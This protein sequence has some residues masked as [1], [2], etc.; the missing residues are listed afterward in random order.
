MTD[1]RKPLYGPNESSSARQREALRETDRERFE[2]LLAHT[3]PGCRLVDVGCG[4]GQFLGLVEDRCRE[5]WAVDESPHRI[6]DVRRECPRAR[7][8][9]CRANR[10]AL[11][12]ERFDAVVTSQMLHEV[13]LFGQPDELNETVSEFGRILVPGGR[14][15]LLDHQDAGEG[16]VVV[17]L[18]DAQMAKLTEFERKYRFYEAAHTPAGAGRIRLSRRCL[19][20]FLTKDCWLGTAMEEME[21][22]ETHNVFERE[23]T[24]ALAG[25]A[26][27]VVR[28]WIDFTDIRDDLRRHVGELIEG[29]P[30]RRKF[31]MVAERA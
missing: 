14:W 31:L 26:G 24:C 30:W 18:P 8:I 6:T 11:A 9:V 2:L 21:M 12:S 23:P 1:N 13:K 16:D 10:L 25:E 15:L 22:N 27:F 17:R 3:P 29:E 7:M 5:I 19:Q 28:E 4:W 20:D